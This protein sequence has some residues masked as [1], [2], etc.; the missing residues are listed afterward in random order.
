MYDTWVELEGT[1]VAAQAEL[2]TLLGNRENAEAMRS[3]AQEAMEQA[4][5]AWQEAGLLGEAAWRAF[6][7][8][9]SVDSPDFVNRLRVIREVDE[10]RKTQAQLQLASNLDAWKE[11]DRARQ[12]ATADI[13]KALTALAAAAA[14]V[15][16]ELRETNYLPDSANSLRNSALDDLRCAH[17]IDEELALMGQEALGQLGASR[18]AEQAQIQEK[19]ANEASARQAEIHRQAGDATPLQEFSDRVASEPTQAAVPEDAPPSPDPTPTV[20]DTP[21][22]RRGRVSERSDPSP[23]SS[24]IAPEA[25]VPEAIAPEPI[26]PDIKPKPSPVPSPQELMSAAEQLR[27]EFEAPTSTTPDTT[28]QTVIQGASGEV[29]EAAPAPEATSGAALSAAEELQREMASMRP[30]ATDSEPVADGVPEAPDDLPSV[31]SDDT[32]SLPLPESYSGKVYF[33]FP[34]TL[35]QDQVGSVWE[36][37]DD[38]AGSGAIVDSRLVSREEGVQFTLELGTKTLTMEALKKK[39]PGANMTALKEDRLKFDWPKPR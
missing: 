15:S 28:G 4:D 2:R 8:G 13:L 24:I 33:M 31:G 27:K 36:A 14:Q 35:D 21:T 37:L 39:M 11:A 18:L 29:I 25:I 19:L 9:F 22:A 16:R 23:E 20:A 38:L 3:E 12:N 6:E 1:I 32:P 7:R 5:A 17:A 30:N 26:V 34:S 10:A